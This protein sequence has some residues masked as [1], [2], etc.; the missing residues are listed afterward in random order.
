MLRKNINLGYKKEIPLRRLADR[1]DM[2]LDFFRD[3]RCA[4]RPRGSA[5]T[6]IFVKKLSFRMKRSEMRNLKLTQIKICMR[7]INE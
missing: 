2:V 3:G 6:P 1:N 7:N 4:T 5:A